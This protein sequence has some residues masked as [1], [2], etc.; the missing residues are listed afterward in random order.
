MIGASS[1]ALLVPSSAR[2]LSC[3]ELAVTRPDGRQQVFSGPAPGPA[4]HVRIIRPNG[5]RSLLALGSGDIRGWL[6]GEWESDDLAALLALVHLNA[7]AFAPSAAGRVRATAGRLFGAASPANVHARHRL[8]ERFYRCW[9]DASLTYSAAAFG[10]DAERTLEQAQIA[11]FDAILDALDPKPGDTLLDMGCGWGAFALH[12]AST[13]RV[14]VHAITIS[15]RQ[16]REVAARASEA[17]LQDLVSAEVLDLRTAQGS[18]YDFVVSIEAYESL[19]RAAWG[20]Y[21][22]A[23]ARCVAPHGVAFMQCAVAAAGAPGK[24]ARK[25]AFLRRY[26]QR[27]AELATRE[28][29][30]RHAERAGLASHDVPICSADDYVRTLQCWRERFEAAAG[31]LT[32]LG[33]DA[34]FQRLWRF[35]L[36][37]CEA[38]YRARATQLMSVRLTHGN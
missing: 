11:K 38:G 28:I 1:G 26:I 3:G 15:A 9:L 24:S 17:G 10:G 19:G 20:R 34:R 36:T 7:E 22:A 32:A 23:I 33:L 2:L 12:A 14:R 6:E 27:S 30:E 16:A 37:W 13:K 35:Y 8:D 25:P 5:M 29:L 31:D 21:F 4:A 18:R